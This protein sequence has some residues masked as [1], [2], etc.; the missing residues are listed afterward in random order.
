M[1]RA[2]NLKRKFGSA[3]AVDDVSFEVKRGDVLG[4][5][6]VNG[7]GKSTTMRMLTGYLTPSEGSVYIN[8]K[9][10][11]ENEQY[12]RGFIGYLPE[13]A[14][15]YLDMRVG[16]FL[17]F[18]AQLRQ[19]QN[20]KKAIVK[21][22]DIC[23]LQEVLYREIGTLSKGYR[24][25]V[26]FAQSIIHNPDIL[27]LDEPTDGLDPAQKNQ[28]RKVIKEYGKDKAII[29]ST[30]ILEEVELLATRVLLL[31]CGKVVVDESIKDFKE[32]N[33]D[34]NETFLQLTN[35]L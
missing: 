13:R 27:I 35:N 21:V 32:R 23:S 30:H 3:I 7:S 26:C 25:R 2:N 28:M 31:N 12:C 24:Q 16:D 33:K 18:C 15:M 6:G 14:P 20:L 22:V 4:F 5:I 19:L 34:L 17:F 1:L 10:L 11:L 8:D 9:F 29:L